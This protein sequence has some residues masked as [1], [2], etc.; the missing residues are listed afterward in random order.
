M[1]MSEQVRLRCPISM[2]RIVHPVK[3]IRCTHAQCFDRSVRI[4]PLFN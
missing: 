4:T 3:G 1:V 2:K